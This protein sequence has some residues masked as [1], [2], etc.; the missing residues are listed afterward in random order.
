MSTKTGK[1]LQSRVKEREAPGRM[2]ACGGDPIRRGKS[3]ISDYSALCS[4]RELYWSRRDLRASMSLM[5]LK[6]CAVG[7]R[8]SLHFP[9]KDNSKSRIR[10][11]WPTQY[12]F[13]SQE[14]PFPTR[15]GRNPFLP[16]IDPSIGTIHVVSASAIAQISIT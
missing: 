11:V 7:Y 13:Q 4:T 1:P 15:H 6:K 12:C 5:D 10:Q 14:G 3:Q 16:N 2:A 9:S 8:S